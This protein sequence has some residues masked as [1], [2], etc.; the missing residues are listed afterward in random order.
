MVLNA[1][2]PILASHYFLRSLLLVFFIRWHRYAGLK[3]IETNIL[4]LSRFK[5]LYIVLP[6]QWQLLNHPLN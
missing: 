6:L 3:Q 2:Q 1:M 4:M 5:P